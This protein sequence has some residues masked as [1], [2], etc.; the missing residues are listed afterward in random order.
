MIK[1]IN[2]SKSKQYVLPIL[3][4]NEAKA[5]S[6]DGEKGWGYSNIYFPIELKNI[7]IALKR[8]QYT[9]NKDFTI[10]AVKDKL[11]FVKT[12]WEWRRV[13]EHENALINFGL[14]TKD[15][16]LIKD[17]FPENDYSTELNQSDIEV[18][19]GIYHSYFVF[20]EI[21]SWLLNPIQHDHS[22][23]LNKVTVENLQQDSSPIFPFLLENRFND[24]FIFSLSD[25]T[26]IFRIPNDNGELMRF[27][28][29]YVKWGQELKLLEKF[30]MKNLDY[31]LS[32]NL[33][34]FACVY[35]INPE[36]PNF[37]LLNFIK[38][39]YQG[40][41][42]HIPNLIL[43]IALKYRHRINDIKQHIIE[44]ALSDSN[45]FSL[46]RTSEIFIRGTEINF[47]PQF[48]DSYIS[49]ILLQ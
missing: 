26:N 48:K 9:E 11:P 38:S 25:S 17:F 21:H 40:K 6:I 35:Y 37:N 45:S 16:K 49:H 8:I 29:V 43:K 34:S 1:Y 39:E 15:R 5:L 33:K 30:N 12:P 10:K 47:V 2:L 13:L 4:S 36:K 42:I 7:F 46:Q 19:K 18:F 28:D 32:N 31:E 14:I 22:S 24:A 3:T 23:F 44:Q 41:H 20:K 27:W